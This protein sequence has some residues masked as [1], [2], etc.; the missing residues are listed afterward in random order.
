MLGDLF[1]F[2]SQEAAS[3]WGPAVALR[4]TRR[5]GTEEGWGKMGLVQ[6]LLSVDNFCQT[7]GGEQPHLPSSRGWGCYPSFP[8]SQWVLLLLPVRHK[9]ACMT[10]GHPHALDT[11]QAPA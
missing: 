4:V 2:H 5:G 1:R 10:H 11:S 9:L 3:C 8:N 7:A 6:I